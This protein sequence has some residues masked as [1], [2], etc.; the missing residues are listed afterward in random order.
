[1]SISWEKVKTTG[2]VYMALLRAHN[3][4]ITVFESFS[5]PDGDMSGRVKGEM[6]VWG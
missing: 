5:D 2:E 4:D 1:M 3:D 6:T